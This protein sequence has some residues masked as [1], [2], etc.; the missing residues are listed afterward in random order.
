MALP[1]LNKHLQYNM[2]I[3]ST[4]QEIKYR[5]YLV[6]EEKHLLLALEQQDKA[7]VL[8][9]IADTLRSCISDDTPVDVSSLPIFDIEY[10]FTQV[11]SKSVGETS[12]INLKCSH[13]HDDETPCDHLNEVD[14]DLSKIKVVLPKGR[15]HDTIILQKKTRSEQR[16]A[17]QMRYPSFEDAASGLAKYGEEDSKIEMMYDQI[18][19]CIEAVIYGEG[20]D[21]QRFDL[22]DES[23]EDRVAFLSYLTGTQMGLIQDWVR[24][25]PTLE[26]KVEFVCQACG[27]KNEMVLKGTSDFF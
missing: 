8:N 21:E 24:A 22:K 4:G 18:L 3:P 14:V 13:V 1:R 27:T 19:L 16:V 25:I 7:V 6:G 2:K 15:N 12:T 10:M 20:D 26:H 23:K 9:A 5:P 17:L 11:R